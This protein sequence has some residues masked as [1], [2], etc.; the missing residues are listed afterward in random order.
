MFDGSQI[1]PQR[2]RV[3]DGLNARNTWIKWAILLQRTRLGK[4]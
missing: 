2:T 1:K 4:M 3:R